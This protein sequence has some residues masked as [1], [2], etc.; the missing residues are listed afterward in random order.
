MSL[1]AGHHHPCVN[2]L[3]KVFGSKV[4]KQL[5]DSEAPASPSDGQGDGASQP[6]P[7][8][9]EVL[10]SLA[11]DQITSNVMKRHL[12]DLGFSNITKLEKQ[13][14]I[15]HVDADWQGRPL[16][17]RIDARLGTIEHSGR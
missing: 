16:K 7:I 2:D 3:Q 14:A 10:I 4:A 11:G 5:G 17:L 12:T 1:G 15:F 8:P 6:S 9:T 13:G